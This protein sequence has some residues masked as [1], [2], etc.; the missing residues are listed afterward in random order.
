[1]NNIDVLKEKKFEYHILGETMQ[2]DYLYIVK[3]IIDTSVI[4]VKNHIMDLIENHYLHE[5]SEYSGNQYES[6]NYYFNYLC[7]LI[8]K[9]CDKCFPNANLDYEK[10]KEYDEWKERFIAIFDDYLFIPLRNEYEMEKLR[11]ENDDEDEE[12]KE[13]LL[14]RLEE[15]KRASKY[16]KS[17]GHLCEEL[18]EECSGFLDEV[19]YSIPYILM[20]YNLLDMRYYEVDRM[21]QLDNDM[22]LFNSK[23]TEMTNKE[24]ILFCLNQLKQNPLSIVSC[25]IILRSNGD[26]D[27]EIH[28]LASDFGY[29][30]IIEKEMDE[31]LENKFPNLF[32]KHYTFEKDVRRDIKSVQ[33]FEELFNGYD[34]GYLDYLEN[35]LTE[36]L[37]K[38]KYILDIENSSDVS[39]AI[40]NYIKTSQFYQENLKRVIDSIEK[41]EKK[42]GSLYNYCIGFKI[43]M[44]N[45]FK[46]IFV[47]CKEEIVLYTTTL[48]IGE[49]TRVSLSDIEF[50]SSNNNYIFITTKEG[51]EYKTLFCCKQSESSLDKLCQILNDIVAVHNLREDKLM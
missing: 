45:N 6:L 2:Y 7:D 5:Q 9:I 3:G 12:K 28:R 18:L 8:I 10:I 50:I 14:E 42:V 39:G 48:F 27:G 35:E 37:L 51:K 26:I 38:K 29:A 49:V 1:M 30:D 15:E 32:N 20:D 4:K 31:I 24:R 43:G 46:N 21:L 40:V 25:R 47:L 44:M 11:I 13:R 34:N 36:V 16:Y 22:E 19:L 23:Y 41:I 17:A 33:D